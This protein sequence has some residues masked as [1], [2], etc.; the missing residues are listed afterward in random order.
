M[1]Q[2]SK[3]LRNAALAAGLIFFGAC[4]RQGGSGSAASITVAQDTVQVFL[5]RTDT[6]KKSV[7]LPGELQPY[8]QTDLYAKVQG[9]VR[10]MKVDLGD[11]VRD[12]LMKDEQRH[13]VERGGPQHHGH[14]PDRPRQSLHAAT[15]PRRGMECRWRVIRRTR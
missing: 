3:E 6:L 7:E 9:Y 13:E 2:Y 12:A 1:A 4:G 10:E 11:R 14:T 5:L 8:F 15:A